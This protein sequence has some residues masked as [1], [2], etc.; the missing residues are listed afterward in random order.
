MNTRTTGPAGTLRRCLERCPQRRPRLA[1]AGLACGL[2][3]AALL[4]RLGE[5]FPADP[6]HALVLIGL[7]LAQAVPLLWRRS[8][9]WPVMAA[10]G[11]AYPVYELTDPLVAF[12]DGLYVL[13]AVYAVGRYARPPGS[14]AAAGVAAAALLLPEVA[15]PWLSLPVPR[16]SVLGPVEALLVTAAAAGAWLLGASQRR[17][18]A[19]AARLRDLAD[20]LRA[21][22]EAGARRAVTAERARIARDL[23]DLV[24]H[25]VSAIALQARATAEALADDPRRAGPGM[26][27]IGEAADTAL[28]EMRRLLGLLT[29]DRDGRDPGPEPSLRHLDR[30]AATARA[31]GCRVEIDTR[32]TGGGDGG[33]GADPVAGV[34]LAVQVSAYRVV[35]EALTNV[36]RHA[37]ATEVDIALRREEGRLT[38]LVGNGP[39]APAHVPAPGSGLGLVGMRERVALFDGVLRAGPRD[40]GWRVEAVFRFPEPAAPGSGAGAARPGGTVAFGSGAGAARPGGTVAFGSGAGAARPGGTVAFGSGAGAAR[41]GGRGAG[42]AG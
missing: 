1:D 18:H 26:A 15:G 19:D 39:P 31:A 29:D 17:I 5:A 8:R 3:A 13:C 22:Q 12:H 28:A 9:P 36:L 11:A 30:L 2:T 41:G 33:S 14:A 10:V 27:G 38:V 32:D 25:H 23:H 7:L 34:P 20:R 37:G 24:A 21:E 16:E 42:G 35:Q 6:V 40:G 4:L